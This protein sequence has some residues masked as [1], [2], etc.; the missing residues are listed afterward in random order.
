M[1]E[2]TDSIIRKAKEFDDDLRKKFPKLEKRERI[3]LW[4]EFIK[5]HD[6]RGFLVVK[7][8]GEGLTIRW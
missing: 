5:F 3:K 6:K 8:K 1:G 2:F 4:E 7:R